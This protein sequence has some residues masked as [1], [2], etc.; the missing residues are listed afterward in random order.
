MAPTALS[1]EKYIPQLQTVELF[2]DLSA[3]DFEPL[4]IAAQVRQIK[5]L[6]TLL[7]QDEIV[8][9]L[10]VILSGRARIFRLCEDGREAV[11]RILCAGDTLFENVIFYDAPSPV[12]GETLKECEVLTIPAEMVRKHA[13]QNARFACNVAKVLAGRT[14]QMMYQIEQISLHPAVHRLGGYFLGAMLDQN[15]SPNGVFE[16]G[17][18]KAM[19]A[20]H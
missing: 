8:T 13:A 5:A 10:F 3:R 2:S 14:N 19:L 11:T 7:R 9:H 18:G 16:L 20:K 12:T 4:L 6:K 1:V 15:S 17:F